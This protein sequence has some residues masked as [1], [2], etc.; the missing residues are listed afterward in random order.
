V[1]NIDHFINFIKKNRDYTL[2]RNADVKK[3]VENGGDIDILVNFF[4]C[5][6]T[7][8]LT[9]T[10]L[11]LMYIKRSYLHSFFWKWAHIDI[12]TSIEFCG[13]NFISNE[14]IISS[15]I[16]NSN[17]LLEAPLHIQA[18]VCWLSNLLLGGFFKSEYKSMIIQAAQESGEAFHASLEYALGPVWGQRLFSLACEERP[19]V[20]EKWIRQLRHSLWWKAFRRSPFITLTRWAN[21]W[22]NQIFRCVNPPAPWVAILGLDGSGKSTIA[23][24]IKEKRGRGKPFMD[25]RI[26]HWRPFFFHKSQDM[27]P[28][29]EPQGKSERG[30]LSS[31]AKLG[32]L[33]LE[34]IFGYWQ[35]I[36]S[37]RAKGQLVIFDRHY[38][39]LL[40]DP[41]RYRYGAPL[42]AARLVGALI[43]KPD[44]FI[45]LDLPAEEA[46]S[47]KPEVPLDEARRL[48]QR[49]LDLTQSL[50][51][52]HVV[53]A[54]RPIDEVIAEV[55]E[56]ILTEQQ[57]RTT[58]R[59]CK[60]GLL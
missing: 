36:L 51:N 49:Y 2:L 43:P 16:V 31:L 3:H 30:T 5:Y 50:P 7:N 42:W 17:E 57:K 32:F 29:V 40:V 1:N 45:L 26:A 10:D 56:I 59:M 38:V 14:E 23:K 13:A 8:L 28:V 37:P 27:G 19:E 18:L 54:A 47:R 20:S 44:L 52:A 12:F 35:C 53:N 4:K 39:D 21:Y 11:P 55:E 41:R 9:S 22:K 6:M 58:A 60:A 15:K 24:S 25:V 48:R 34:W 33:V 46:R